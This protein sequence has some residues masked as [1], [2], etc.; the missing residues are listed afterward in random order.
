M[1]R[2]RGD[3]MTAEIAHVLHTPFPAVRKTPI[4]LFLRMHAQALRI[5]KATGLR[6]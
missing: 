4:T 6:G 3:A 2:R 1:V 5:Q